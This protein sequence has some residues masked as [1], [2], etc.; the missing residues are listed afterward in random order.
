MGADG[1]ITTLYYRTGDP[2]PTKKRPKCG[3]RCCRC[4]HKMVD[5]R[6]DTSGHNST[7]GCKKMKCCRSRGHSGAS[8][9]I[10]PNPCWDVRVYACI[11]GEQCGSSISGSGDGSGAQ[12]DAPSGNGDGGC[13]V[14][15]SGCGDCGSCGDCGGCGDSGCGD[16]VSTSADIICQPELICCPCY[17]CYYC[18]FGCCYVLSALG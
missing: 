4:S 16:C 6:D 10:G 13:K 3:H 11:C 8:N 15:C 7:G 5:D 1:F 2:D 9:A 12:I 17:V 14:N 18:C